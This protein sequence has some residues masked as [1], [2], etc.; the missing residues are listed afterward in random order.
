M[1]D[2]WA[3]REAEKII[4]AFVAYDGPDDF[5]QLQQAIAAALCRAFEIG[6]HG[7]MPDMPLDVK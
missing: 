3:E 2:N 5:L 6:C 4:D 7:K 1:M